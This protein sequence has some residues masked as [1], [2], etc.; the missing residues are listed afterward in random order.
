MQLSDL[1]ADW[2]FLPWEEKETVQ[3]IKGN[4]LVAGC[5]SSFYTESL[6]V[7][8]AAGRELTAGRI[9]VFY[10]NMDS[11]VES[12]L[13]IDLINQNQIRRYDQENESSFSWLLVEPV[14]DVDDQKCELSCWRKLGNIDV[15]R[16]IMISDYRIYGPT[17]QGFELAENE[18]GRGEGSGNTEAY[19]YQEEYVIDWAKSRGISYAILR[20]GELMGGFASDNPLQQ[21]IKEL[22]E[23]EKNSFSCTRRKLPSI[24]VGDYLR[25]VFLVC[26]NIKSGI[27]NV[28]AANLSESDVV[29]Y[30]RDVKQLN[31]NIQIIDKD[32]YA[33]IEL[34]TE[35]LTLE[36]WRPLVSPEDYVL[37]AFA[38]F[39]NPERI[40]V[41]SDYLPDP[42][43]ERIQELL[44]EMLR[45]VNMICKKHDIP[46]YLAG[47]TLL[48]AIRNHGFLPWDND[49]DLM[50]TRE[51]YNKFLKVAK[52][53]L[54]EN[55]FLQAASYDPENHFY[56]KIRM[57][58][59]L[60]VTPF[61]AKHSALHNGIF[62]DI[63][64]QDATA[65]KKLGQ[66][67]HIEATIVARSMVFNKWG[68]TEIAGDGSHPWIRRVF[69]IVKS[70]LP[71]SVLE[72]IQYK[73]IRFFEWK[74]A[75]IYLYDGMGQ[76]IRRGAF[77]AEWLKEEESILFEGEYFPAPRF[78][79]E[80]LEYLYGKDYKYPVALIKRKKEH[81]IQLV[82]LGPHA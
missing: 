16:V 5:G 66:K 72:K 54:P 23:G 26:R 4:I 20:P 13:I 74:K 39:S 80:Y 57:N 78:A 31:R 8:L 28:S 61:N 37:Y 52:D 75:P 2:A 10:Y 64:P 1:E 40:F 33:G 24:Y 79:H 30:L 9:N 22:A 41:Y 69:S 34:S 71:M 76:N 62:L 17:A 27:W 81:N 70:C 3:D 15:R 21:K 60:L 47:G 55:L 29:F 12:D 51:A 14:T 11:S 77:P 35:R 67:I 68:N 63:F 36:G 38:F 18:L 46:Y 6:L 73:T 43:L 59:T 44:M 65:D 82:D 45:Q 58:H 7:S 32:E 25:A 50:M 56:S 48:G 49:L 42:K 53:E 19:A